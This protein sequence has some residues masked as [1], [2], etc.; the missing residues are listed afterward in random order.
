[1][2]YV[3]RSVPGGTPVSSGSGARWRRG[4]GLAR[5][6]TLCVVAAL[7]ASVAP[8]IGAS[9]AASPPECAPREEGGPV[10]VTAEC[11]DPRYNRPVIDSQTDV[12]E[13]VPHHRVSGHF[14]GTDY[15]FNFYF[16]PE[17]QWEGR[18]F[19]KVYPLAAY[20]DEN[21]SD[22][23][24]AFGADSGAYTVQT[25]G[26]GGYRVDAA[27]AK[28]SETVA[29]DYYGQPDRRI[30]GY[31]Y[32]GSGGSFQTIGATENSTG[33]WE[34]AVPFIPGSPTSMAIF[35]RAFARLVLRDE[36]PRIADAVAP[37]G[38]G[39]PYA[40]L[41]EVERSVLAEVTRMGVPLRGWE[42][43]SYLLG[44]ERPDG[45]LGFGPV[46]RT[47]D[48]TYADD[49]WNKP[50]YLGTEQSP[51]GDIIRAA[52]IDQ[53]ATITEV[54]RDDQNVPTRLVLDGVPVVESTIG[55]D[56][57]VHDADGTT[58]T[59]TLTGTLDPATKTFTVGEGNSA[60]VLD[61]IDAG[62]RLR[63]DNRWSVA[64]TSYHRHQ[65]PTRPGFHAWDQF[66][67]ANG[68]PIYP[69]RPVQV[70]PMISRSTSGGGT[71][72]GEINGKVIVVAN[73]L[74]VDAYPWHGDWY[75]QQVNQALGDRYDD[76]FRLWYTDNADHQEGDVTGPRAA[77]LV[78][79]NGTIQQ[80]VRDVS[81]WV[82]RGV[83]PPRSTRY[84]VDDSQ[85]GVPED[86]ARRGG[87]QPVVDLTVDGA[88]RID[89]VAG[90]PVTFTARIQAPPRSGRVVATAWDFTGTGEFTPSPSRPPRQTVEVQATFTYASPGVYFPVLRATSQREGDA[91]TPFAAV[92]NLD[93]VRVVVHER[94]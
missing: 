11:V 42:D 88:Q 26:N 30:Y 32:G 75:A 1:M 13:P 35:P 19:H 16:P 92:Q 47:M 48:P 52:R 79:F 60:D 62:D 64:L 14:E 67:D 86:A 76:S 39:N 74:D 50:G 27:A 5:A 21:A 93:R 68:S 91:S 33:V 57:T 66:R 2:R 87:I 89:V 71:H 83:A 58:A 6:T 43:Y 34:G 20:Q 24:I 3:K 78:D 22:E 80:A 29:A 61:A 84:D 82:E 49:F 31:V 28:F 65:V 10:W 63:I 72:T 77:R 56:Y 40:G 51:L 23:T 12:T 37:G 41:T 69:Q 55:L 70:G 4:R 25:N 81:A 59:G 8:G 44:L 90:E 85:I 46:I 73:L 7:V 18:F 94:G 53:R 15:R 9:A 36:A 17:E 38:S 45:L 54:D